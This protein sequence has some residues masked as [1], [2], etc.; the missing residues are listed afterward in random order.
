LSSKPAISAEKLAVIGVKTEPSQLGL[1][2]AQIF[3]NNL[4]ES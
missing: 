4:P 2:K 3:A 1:D